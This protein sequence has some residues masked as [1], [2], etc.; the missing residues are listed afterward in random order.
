MSGVIRLKKA[1]LNGIITRNTI[2]VPCIVRMRLYWS[3]LRTPAFGTTSWVRRRSASIPPVRKKM[4]AV[5]P[6]IRPM[7]LWS[8][9]AIQL[10]IP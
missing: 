6:Y 2:V 8:T 7:R 4:K 3:A 9:V 10:Q 1:A 5:T